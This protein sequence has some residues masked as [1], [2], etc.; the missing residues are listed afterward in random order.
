M[1]P[2]FKPYMS[3]KVMPALA[4]VLALSWIGQGPA[5]DSV[6]KKF[7]RMFNTF[8]ALTLNSCTSALHLALVLADVKDGDEVIST[9]LTCSA[10]NIPILYQRA[11]PVFADI[12]KTALNI[13][14]KSIKEK[15]SKKTKAIVIV[16]WGGEPCD[17][18][19]ILEIARERKIPVIEDA[20]HALGAMYRGK[21]IG[22][23][24][25]FT[26]FS[27]QAIKQITSV[28][29]GIL[30]CKDPRAYKRGKLLR[31]YGIDRASKGDIYWKFKVEEAGFKYHMNDVTATILSIQLDDLHKVNSRRKEIADR[32]RKSLNNIPGLTLLETKKDRESGYWLF[33]VLVERREDFIKMMKDN[34]IETHMVHIRCDVYPIFGGKRLKLPVMNE[35]EPKYV[36]IPLH[37][38]LTDDDVEKIITTIK[39]GW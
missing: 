22:T 33:T 25:D 28:D 19:E 24:S 15:L 20:A 13:D 3:E 4:E 26:C 21:Y 5:V 8:G 6:E 18:D 23:I 39:K 29:G 7:E 1:I 17:M 37:A 31:W 14:P 10:T 36:S 35:I 12:Q 34:G 38:A 30:V 11:K 27:F 16:H 9:P 32:Y 2:M